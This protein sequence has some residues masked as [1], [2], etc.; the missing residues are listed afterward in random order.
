MIQLGSTN[1]SDHPHVGTGVLQPGREWRD[2]ILDKVGDAEGAEA[3]K[4]EAADGGVL[5]TAVPL[6]E[7]D[8]EEG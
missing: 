7:V 2:E 8:G 5:I 4:R 1:S 6:E 3:A